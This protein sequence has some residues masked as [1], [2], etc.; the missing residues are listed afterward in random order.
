M[1]NLI[2][3]NPVLSDHGNII[4][5]VLLFFIRKH[6]VNALFALTIGCMNSRKK[7]KWESVLYFLLT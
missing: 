7:W 3:K 6:N 5:F 2:R 1:Q 4:V